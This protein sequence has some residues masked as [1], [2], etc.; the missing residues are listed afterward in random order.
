VSNL[1]RLSPVV[2]LTE[3]ESSSV[4]PCLLVNKQCYLLHE[5]AVRLYSPFIRSFGDSG[6][7]HRSE[8]PFE[9]SLTSWCYRK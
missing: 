9:S 6:E 5:V 2:I 4:N 1:V 3:F 8:G 7:L